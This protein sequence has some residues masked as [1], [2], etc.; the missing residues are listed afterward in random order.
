MYANRGWWIPGEDGG[1]ER[2]YKWPFINYELGI[3]LYYG[4]NQKEKQI[5]RIKECGYAIIFVDSSVRDFGFLN[6]FPKSSVMIFH[7]SDET[8][9]IGPTFRMLRNKSVAK[10]F[11]DYPLRKLSNIF[12]W[13]RTLFQSLIRSLRNNLKIAIFFKSMLFG[14]ALFARQ[15]ITLLLSKFYKKEIV[16]LPLGYTN[17]FSEKYRKKFE[18]E[19][20]TSLLDFALSSKEIEIYNKKNFHTF[21][22]GQLGNFDR[23]LMIKEALNSNLKLGRVFFRFAA[24]DNIDEQ[25]LSFT[26]YLDGLYE[27]RFS[28]CPPGNYS[29]E[30]FRLFE[31]LLLWATPVMKEFVVSEPLYKGSEFQGWDEFLESTR[32]QRVHNIDCGK[33]VESGLLR[34]KS[35]LYEV[36]SSIHLH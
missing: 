26:Q 7:V 18:L 9:S 21:F 29:V 2:E 5:L 15:A 3:S 31:S 4:E 28:L 19:S 33:L 23:Q 36:R 35:S 8:Y 22:S 6:N 13:P 1:P 17:G 32:L 16:H 12:Y 14:L 30:T 34:F 11:R 20:D 10:L 25:E 24:S 27:S